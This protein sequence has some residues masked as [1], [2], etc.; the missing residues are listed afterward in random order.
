MLLLDI[1]CFLEFRHNV[2]TFR[3]TVKMWI[4]FSGVIL[5]MKSNRI[6]SKVKNTPVS[7]ANLYSCCVEVNFED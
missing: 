5:L 3:Y 1:A 6:Y 7:M 2:H 4:K